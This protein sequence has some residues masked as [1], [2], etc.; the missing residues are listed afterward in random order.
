MGFNSGFKGLTTVIQLKRRRQHLFD[1]G[2]EMIITAF[3][4]DA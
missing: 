2:N 1:K 3:H 4:T